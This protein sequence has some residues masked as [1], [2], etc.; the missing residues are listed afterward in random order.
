MPP[1]PI[2]Q[3]V[4]VAPAVPIAPPAPMPLPA[5]V[6]PPVPLTP[7]VPSPVGLPRPAAIAPPPS[8]AQPA[9][10]LPLARSPIRP[11]APP[12]IASDALAGLDT[13][14]RVAVARGASTLYLSS[15]SRPS[16]R[17][18]GDVHPEPARGARE[19]RDVRQRAVVGREI[20]E[21]GQ[22]HAAL[23][24]RGRAR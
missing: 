13:L 6:A 16:M 23:T 10:V 18:D 5:L 9:V 7:Y 1:A 24:D 14:L 3:P 22:M 11:E 2:A 8:M 20:V 17:V 15:A 19:L 12:R 21:V 4:A